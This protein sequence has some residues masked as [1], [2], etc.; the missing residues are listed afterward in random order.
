VKKLGL[1]QKQ[2]HLSKAGSFATCKQAMLG[3]YN[4]QAVRDL[5]VFGLKRD[6]GSAY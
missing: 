1:L 6:Y 3:L 5:H 4:P 2:A